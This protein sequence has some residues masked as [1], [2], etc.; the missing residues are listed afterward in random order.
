MWDQRRQCKLR[1]VVIVLHLDDIIKDFA[2]STNIFLNFYYI[3]SWFIANN[4]YC[5]FI[6]L[7]VIFYAIVEL[8]EHILIIYGLKVVKIYLVLEG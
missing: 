5:N 7:W 1:D 6:K 8:F 3:I 4:N 2:L